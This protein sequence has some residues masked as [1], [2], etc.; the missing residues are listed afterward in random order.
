MSDL[1]NFLNSRRIMVSLAVFI[2]LVISVAIFVS[3]AESVSALDQN[4]CLACHSKLDA[5]KTTND[6]RNVSLKINADTV[7]NS[8]H[9]FIDCTTCHGTD[10]H[11]TTQLSKQ[12]SAQLCGTCHQYEYQQF[13]TSIHGQQLAKGNT[14]V[15]TCADCH[16]ADGDPHNIVRVLD[17][18]S[19][20]YKKNIADT[21]GK[22][23]NNQDL[24]NDY[25]IV[26]KVYETYM[27]SFHGKAIELGSDQITKLNAATCT[28]C[29][30]SHNIKA[31]ND[32]TAPVAGMDNLVQTCDQCHTGAGSE[33]V[34]G[35][36]GHK[37]ASP[38]YVP[39]AH[40][41]EKTFAVLF[42]SVIGVGGLVLVGAVIGYSRKR[43]RR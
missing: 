16:S 3:R 24:M 13:T 41:V 43:W 22:C 27:Q 8:A 39:Q 1:K 5:G 21:C 20:T 29:H 23:H 32:P 26:E 7:N 38:S 4:N 18:T 11:K 17:S 31:V 34:K 28:N 35:F 15:A 33:F 42:Y 40:Y 30:G 12:A 19:T 37:E 9:K 6:G 10:A 25:G 36:L 14:D 2:G